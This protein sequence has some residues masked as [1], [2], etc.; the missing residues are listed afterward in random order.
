MQSFRYNILSETEEVLALSYQT[1]A[2]S[3]I[4]EAQ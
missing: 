1:F 3:V 4:L 2:S